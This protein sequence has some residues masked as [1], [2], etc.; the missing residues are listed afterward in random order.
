LEE[1]VP[2]D[3]IAKDQH[4]SV[5]EKKMENIQQEVISGETVREHTYKY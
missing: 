2:T 4:F 5:A 1:V 3:G